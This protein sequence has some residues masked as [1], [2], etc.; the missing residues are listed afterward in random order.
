VRVPSAPPLI[1]KT[2]SL[3]GFFA[4][5][6]LENAPNLYPLSQRDC[7]FSSPSPF[8]VMFLWLDEVTYTASRRLHSRPL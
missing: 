3:T 2:Q 7:S 8:Y 1:L 5:W 6:R 4:I